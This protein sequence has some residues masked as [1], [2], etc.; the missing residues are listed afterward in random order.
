M[1]KAPGLLLGLFFFLSTSPAQSKLHIAV[2]DTGFCNQSQL[3]NKPLD[4]TSSVKVDCRKTQRDN[5]RFHGHFVLKNFLEHN[6]RKDI[7][8]SPL[9]VFD[10]QGQQ[11]KEYWLKA[12]EWIK[13][14]Q[15]DVLL[16]ASGLVV[17]TSLGELPT[18][19]VA[20]SGQVSGKIRRTHQLW[21][22]SFDSSKLILIGNLIRDQDLVFAGQRLLH[23]KRIDYFI[24][25]DSSSQAV[26]KALARALN[27]CRSTNIKKCFKSK[28]KVISDS[29]TN[30]KL[31]VL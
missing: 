29:L 8:I 30:A 19:T 18:L 26:A 13:S 9:I 20:A 5:R 7:K 10:K 22:Q 17:E 4:F 2:I 11:K 25:E 21:P 27:N 6:Q 15:V 12:L 23:K 3:V 16:T 1:T 14:N 31:S 28:A 24:E